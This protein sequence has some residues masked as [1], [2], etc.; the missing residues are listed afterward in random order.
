MPFDLAGFYLPSFFAE[1]LARQPR[2]PGTGSTSAIMD[3]T[4]RALIQ[5][6]SMPLPAISGDCV[7]AELRY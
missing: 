5:A 1:T 6:R 2:A 4:Q 3:A 7:L